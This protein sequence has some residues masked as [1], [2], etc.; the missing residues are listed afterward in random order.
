MTQSVRLF[1]FAV[2]LAASS[3]TLA[4]SESSSS[5]T[6]PTS[7]SGSSALT[8][9]Q[10]AGTWT[11]ASVQPQG[12][13]AQA[14]PGGATYTITFGDQQL[15]TRADCNTCGGSYSIAGQTLTTGALAC[16]R[17]ACPT[18]AFESTYTQML[19]GTSTVAIAG[20]TLTLT[21]TRGA[22]RFVR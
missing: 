4:C 10:L 22:L 7:S 6:S 3:F 9:G 11:L 15:S 5:P 16:T 12:Q 8:A 13:A 1:A 14:V 21:S 2:L 18:M 17:A 19:G 20:S